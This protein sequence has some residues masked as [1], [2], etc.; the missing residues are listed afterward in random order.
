LEDQPSETWS[1]ARAEAPIEKAQIE[2]HRI[3]GKF[4]MFSQISGY[5]EPI[6][7][8]GTHQKPAECGR[9]P[10]CQEASMLTH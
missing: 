9:S 4:K 5:V 2:F 10:A 7:P 6:S 1:T 3:F 8:N